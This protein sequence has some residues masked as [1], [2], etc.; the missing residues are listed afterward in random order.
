MPDRKVLEYR[1]GYNDQEIESET[2]WQAYTFRE[3]DARVARFFRVDPLAKEYPH[4]TPYQFAGNMPVEFKE[5]EG[6]EPGMATALQ[7][8]HSLINRVDVNNNG[9]SANSNPFSALPSSVAKVDFDNLNQSIKPYLLT[10]GT[11]TEFSD[12]TQNIAQFLNSRKSFLGDKMPNKIL[13]LQPFESNFFKATKIVG[14]IAQGGA[15]TISTV[16]AVQ[17]NTVEGYV[18]MSV[19][20]FALGVSRIPWIGV[21]LA[22]GIEYAD[23]KGYLDSF[24]NDLSTTIRYGGFIGTYYIGPIVGPPTPE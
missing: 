9:K 4:W 18:D 17:K 21:P 22:F 23:Y 11:A 3:Y 10:L 5:L 14:R 2:G 16:A 12:E 1:Y 20:L 6:A 8:A 24:K 15:V 7:G 13:Q 19:D